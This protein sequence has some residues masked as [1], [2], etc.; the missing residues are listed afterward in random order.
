MKLYDYARAPSPRRVRIFLAEKGLEVE[1]VQVDLATGAQFGDDFRRRNPDCTV[2]VLELDDGQCISEAF[3][4]SD[5]LEAAYPE[6]PLL[7]HSAAERGEIVMWNVRIEQQGLMACMEA[8]RNSV[9]GLARRALPGTDEVEQIPALAERGLQRA[10]RFL[11]RLDAHLDGRD[12]IAGEHYS[13]ADISALVFVDFAGW[14]KIA[15][16]EGR[17]ALAR[18][19]EVV[20][21]RPSAAA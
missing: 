12:W 5:Y 21:S 16:T 19:Y 10:A 3:A 13:V 11:D 7:G 9:K 14:V 17:P 2:P 8:F 20:S 6:P 18:W 4:I 1:T 15:A